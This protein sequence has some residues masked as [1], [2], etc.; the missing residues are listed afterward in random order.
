MSNIEV[1]LV[2]GLKGRV[3]EVFLRDGDT[4]IHECVG[5]FIYRTI[6]PHDRRFEMR[7]M[8]RDP[9]NQPEPLWYL[10]S[11]PHKN[12]RTF[13]TYVEAFEELFMA[14]GGFYQ[15]TKIIP[16]PSQPV[17]TSEQIVKAAIVFQV[18]HDTIE[19]KSE[20]V[21]TATRH[22]DCFEVAARE[23]D[24]TY[25]KDECEQGFW[26]SK[27]RFVDRYEAK[28]IAMENGQ[29]KEDTGMAELYSEDLW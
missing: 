1:L 28:H 13:H 9:D 10:M 22:A 24:F 14:A 19:Q 21:V 25:K 2:Y 15:D 6:S 11:I 8:T 29:L 16:L 23:Y 27:N 12:T 3:A 26:T 7:Q 20:V 4:I 17:D 18:Y 5:D